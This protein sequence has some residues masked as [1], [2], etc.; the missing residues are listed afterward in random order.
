MKKV[1]V[2][3]QSIFIVI[4]II[5]MT[6][7]SC[8]KTIVGEGIIVTEILQISE[9]SGVDLTFS[10]NVTIKYGQIQEVKVTGNPNIIERI[11][12]S[13]LNNVWKI[14]LIEGNYKNYELAIEITIPN[15]DILKLSGSGNLIVDDF[16]VQKDLDLSISGS[17][18]ITLNNIERA[19]NLDLSISGSGN[20][21]LNNLKRTINLDVNLSGSGDLKANRDITTLETLTIKNS[22][23]GRYLGFIISCNNVSSNLSGSGKMELTANNSLDVAISGSGNVYYKGTPIITQNITGSGILINA[24]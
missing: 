20:I 1:L 13:V 16:T 17:G 4:A 5:T 11:K 18:N 6:F 14:G 12:T 22:G 19:T 15:L 2:L 21:I 9:F 24:N 8:E 7:T 10:D 23:S 3:K